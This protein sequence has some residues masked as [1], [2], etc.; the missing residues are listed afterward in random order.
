MARPSWWL[1]GI[2]HPHQVELVP[3]RTL[4]VGRAPESDV[5]VAD[6]TV[7]RRHAELIVE[8]GRIRV[9]DT[10]SSNGTAIN[11]ARLT[12]GELSPNDTIVFGKVPY[13][14]ACHGAEPAAPD[15]PLDG[16]VV[17]RI[18]LGEGVDALAE[19]PALRANTQAHRLARLLD[20]TKRLSGEY[21]LEKLLASVV[22]L[23]FELLPVDRVS[24][25]LADAETGEL[26]PALSRSRLGDAASLRVPRSIARLAALDRA[27]IITE[28]ATADDR[29]QSGSVL[30]QSVR[31]A[32]CTPL[33]ATRTKVLG[34]LYVDTLTANEPFSEDDATL[35]FAFGGLAAVSIA[36]IRYAD[37]IRREAEVRTNFERFFAPGVAARIATERGTIGL[38]GERRAVT[39]LFSDIRGFTAITET[40]HPE[41]I[42]ELL[43]A[44]FTEMV[45]IV[46]E[47]GGTLDKFIG[48]A[49]L[50]VWGAPLSAAD[51]ADR[52]LAAALAMQRQLEVLNGRW[53]AAGR[54]TLAIGIGLNHGEVFAGYL[55]SE[56]RLEYSVLGDTVN[57]ASR[58][59][60]EAAGGEIF[61]TE[62][63]LTA[64]TQ[65]PEVEQ[66]ADL[67]LKGKQQKVSVWR[68]RAQGLGIRPSA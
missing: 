30:L 7:S 41:A 21:E 12:E 3:G 44:Y 58:L 43:T 19:A 10:G 55:G 31:G 4:V 51:D 65:R 53:R 8:D 22:E 9:R 5:L 13:R 40:M 6:V 61:V 37:E 25:L 64:L 59:C 28:N 52:A 32:I 68:V 50:A 35:L 54:P 66:L 11:G 45:D 15:P 29:F 18:D 23:T 49:I 39:V 62:S 60:D 17:R 26:V 14:L 34:A 48:D 67:E 16:T 27:P 47:H 57:V 33:L 36:K 1:E 46:F 63:V 42:A 2:G 24:L 38:G 20:L 56:R